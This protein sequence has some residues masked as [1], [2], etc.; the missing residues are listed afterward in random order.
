MG[1]DKA[2]MPFL[3]RPLILRILERLVPL[4]DEVFLSTNHLADYTFLGLPLHPDLL[5]D[6]GS[7][8]GLYTSLNA[9]QSSIVAVVACDM[10]FASPSLFVYECELLS[11]TGADVVIPS[12]PKGLEPLHAV[13]RRDTCLR[14]IQSALEAGKLKL[15]GW[16]PEVNVRMV[17]PQETIRFDPQGLAFWNLN[18]PEEF[19]QAEELARLEENDQGVSYKGR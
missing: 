10:P 18:T 15:V 12:T 6:S 9:A 8:G 16:L 4:A 3:G 2:L 7:L 14:V 11:K 5:P 17:M 1:Q 19:R 13:Y